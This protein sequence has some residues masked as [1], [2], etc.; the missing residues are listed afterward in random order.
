M[1]TYKNWRL[2]TD[3]DKILWLYFDKQNTSVNT[4]DRETMGELDSILDSL[5]SDTQ[6]KGII[7]TS[8]KDK[9]F[10]A[11]ADISQFTKFKDEPEAL[12]LLKKGQNIF[13]KIE[14][15]KM[16]SVAMINGFSFGGGTELALACRYR[17]ALDD[18]K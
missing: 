1:Q 18:L 3:A 4:L 2:E 12:D 8:A 13:Q 5:A 14:S 9:G 15:L 11:G 10:I 17:V 6:H 16:P 7:I